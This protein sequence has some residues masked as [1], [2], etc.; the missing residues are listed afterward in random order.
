MRMN[1]AEA[2]RLVGMKESREYTSLRRDLHEAD[3]SHLREAASVYD[4]LALATNWA[5]IDCSMAGSG[6]TA[7]MLRPDE[8]H[9]QVIATFDGRLPEFSPA[10]RSA[11]KNV[12]RKGGA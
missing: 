10:V 2:Q 1:V 3:S 12:S 8:I 9:A 6:D 11:A 7:E 4:R 5:T